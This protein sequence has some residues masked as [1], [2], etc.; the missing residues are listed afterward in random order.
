ML[1]LIIILQSGWVPGLVR[2]YRR[3]GYAVESIQAYSKYFFGHYQIK[4]LI[5]TVRKKISHHGKL[6]KR[7]LFNWLKEK[8]IKILVMLKKNC[9]VL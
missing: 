4:E 9:I 7:F 2:H 6:L 5:A 8:C 3:N 1:V